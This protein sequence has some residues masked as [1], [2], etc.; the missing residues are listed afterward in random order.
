MART[1][2]GQTGKMTLLTKLFP[3]RRYVSLDLPAEAQLVAEDP[4]T[5]LARHPPPL[6]VD[7]VQYWYS[8]PNAVR[9][10][11]RPDAEGRF[12]GLLPWP[13]P[14]PLPRAPRRKAT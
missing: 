5:F 4:G 12:S 8:E 10:R 6:L 1:G 14:A 11:R 7:A 3:E 13:P 2:G 9:L